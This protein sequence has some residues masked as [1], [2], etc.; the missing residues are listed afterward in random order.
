MSTQNSYDEL[1][2]R[3][4][5]ISLL[6][7]TGAILH[8][9]QQTYM[10][11]GA[12]AF[13]ADQMVLLSNVTHS[14]FTDPKIGELISE[15]EQSDMVKDKES[16]EAVNIR[17]L[18]WQYDKQT[19]L[20]TDLVEEITKTTTLAHEKWAEARSK[21]DFKIFLPWFEKVI[22]LEKKKAEA[23]GYEGEPYNA[24][25]DD[26]E[27]GAT[28]DDVVDV[29]KDLRNELV[30]LLQK[31]QNAPKK[32]DFSIVEREYDVKLQN[33]FGESVAAALGFDFN[34][35]RLDVTTHPF[36]TGIGVGDTRIL[37]RYNPN[38]LNDALFGTMHEAGHG[39]Y[40]SGIDKATHFGTPM[41]EAVSLGIH[42]SQSRMWENQ[43]G[44][45]KS[46]WKYFFPQAQRLFKKSL[47]GVSLDDF[48]GAI[49]NVTPSY[50]RVE[51]DEATYNLHI[52]LR[53]ELERALLTGD[54]KP[55][56]VPGEWNSRFKKYFGIEV[57]KDANGCLQDV[58]WSAGLVGYFPTYTLGNLYSA[59][60]FDKAKQEMP[61]LYQQFER[62]DFLQ[63]REWLREKIHVHGQRYR[64]G[65]LCK[66]VTGKPLDYK[67]LINYMT[68][69]YSEIYGF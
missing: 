7:S 26:Y 22:A 54:L 11:H 45:S 18:R 16:P 4:R 34:T 43:V 14:K 69:K 59:C 44:R 30:D 19:K 12:G 37:T 42:E 61:D 10:P 41:G 25:L 15:L 46:F 39:L 32:P 66:K 68:A 3:C 38:R 23:Y 5:E 49:N 57:D 20:P 47:S 21:S 60:F 56:D 8:W 6:A 27:P 67:P 58:H 40:E 24:L 50:I 48:Y 2:K 51:A 52:L 33:I 13:R 35:G 17:E 64:A 1:I 36:C 65:D 28:V 62:G 53:F 9:D 31:I 55:A 63:L 29:F